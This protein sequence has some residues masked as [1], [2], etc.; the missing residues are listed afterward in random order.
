MPW[1]RPSEGC[2][3]RDPAGACERHEVRYDESFAMPADPNTRRSLACHENGH[4]LGLTHEDTSSCMHQPPTSSTYGLTSY[5]ID[6]IQ[7]HY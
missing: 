7:S 6:W 3:A 2:A 1:G 5:D 4:T